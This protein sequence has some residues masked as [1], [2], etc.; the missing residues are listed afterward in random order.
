VPTSANPPFVDRRLLA[1][2]LSLLDSEREGEALAAGRQ[3]SKM[4]ASAG[5]TWTD[6]ICRPAP[7]A[8]IAAPFPVEAIDNGD[9]VLLPPVGDTWY[10]TARWLVQR[11]AGRTTFEARFLV[12][13]LLAG[14]RGVMPAPWDAAAMLTIYRAHA[15]P[16]EAQS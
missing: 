13:M 2:V 15:M 16:G 14:E 8:P 6:I 1:K 10:A 11:Q 12:R 7:A 3:A 4:L 9:G 5:L